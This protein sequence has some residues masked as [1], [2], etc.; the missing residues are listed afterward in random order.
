[1]KECCPIKIHTAEQTHS[2]NHQ[3]SKESLTMNNKNKYLK[4]ETKQLDSS[5]P[6]VETQ[7]RAL[8]EYAKLKKNLENTKNLN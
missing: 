1:M 4:S 8:R 2:K 7:D 5:F 6:G 3:F